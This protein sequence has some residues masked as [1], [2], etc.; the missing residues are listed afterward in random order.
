[1]VEAPDLD[2]AFPKVIR[3][4]TQVP[5]REQVNDGS[6][7]DGKR[8]GQNEGISLVDVDGAA[9]GTHRDCIGEA[10]GVERAVGL[11]EQC[12]APGDSELELWFPVADGG[13]ERGAMVGIVEDRS[14][15]VNGRIQRLF[16][17][18]RD[19]WFRSHR[20]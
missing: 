6:G 9:V 18:V 16:P 5:D 4:G 17:G 2:E 12:I 20:A 14:A 8:L 1:M 3:R 11:V 10:N 13:G 19:V 7:V 15:L